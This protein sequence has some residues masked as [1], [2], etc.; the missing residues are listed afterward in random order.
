MCYNVVI[1]NCNKTAGMLWFINN[2]IIKPA[3]EF[4]IHYN[5]KKAAKAKLSKIYN[6]A[7]KNA[8]KQGKFLIAAPPLKTL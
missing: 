7:F 8:S 2:P 1:C 5:N 3:L 4:F 6:L